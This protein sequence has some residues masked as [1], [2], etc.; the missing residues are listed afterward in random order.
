[1]NPAGRPTLSLGRPRGGR[2]FVGMI[3][4]ALGVILLVG[5]LTTVGA[6][7]LVLAL[8]VVF[9]AGY[10][11]RRGY[12]L[13]VAGGILT[14]LG[15]GIVV[16]HLAGKGDYTVL[17][18]GLGFMLIFVVDYLLTR[19]QRRWWPLIPGAALAIVGLSQVAPTWPG[20]NQVGRYWPVLLILLGVLYLVNRRPA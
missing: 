11:G 10:A 12:G 1:M 17:G 3:L 16:G 20:W 7:A 4:I 15:A 6:D 5:N 2:L 8:G 14:G 9:L 18:L 13:L 19:N